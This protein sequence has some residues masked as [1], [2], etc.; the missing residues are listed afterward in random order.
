MTFHIF[1][2]IK[3]RSCCE[4]GRTFSL[5]ETSGG[6]KVSPNERRGLTFPGL[7]FHSEGCF[8]LSDSKH[9]K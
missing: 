9:I 2:L 8:T 7:R 5:F 1:F 6:K 4:R 3:H